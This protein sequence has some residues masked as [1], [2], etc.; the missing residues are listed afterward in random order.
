MTQ[1]QQ[2]SKAVLKSLEAW[3]N[4]DT[5]PTDGQRN[6]WANE[7]RRLRALELSLRPAEV[8]AIDNAIDCAFERAFPK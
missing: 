4:M 6:Y 2:Y 3:E 8:V 7:Y 1:A 5:A